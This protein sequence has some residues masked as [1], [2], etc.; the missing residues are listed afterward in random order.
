MS[1]EKEKKQLS[2]LL[3]GKGIL[4]PYHTGILD[5]HVKCIREYGANIFFYTK[6][7]HTIMIDA[8]YLDYPTLRK[9][10]ERIEIVPEEIHEILLTHADPDHV[11]AID[12]ES[13][14]LFSKAKVFMS[15]VE[16]RYVTGG[17]TSYGFYVLIT[18]KIF[19][20]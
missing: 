18:S 9:K 13:E 6:G 15:E 12:R 3:K 10:M 20:L 16:H 1:Q 11:G 14:G 5:E 8:G 4:N 17:T 7:E 2:A 19:S